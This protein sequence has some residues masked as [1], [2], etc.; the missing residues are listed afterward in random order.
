MQ[1]AQSPPLGGTAAPGHQKNNNKH[2][3]T[4]AQKPPVAITTVPYHREHSTPRRG[5]PAAP[6]ARV[7]R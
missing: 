7:R 4:Q 6:G 1:A 5:T 2:L 3:T